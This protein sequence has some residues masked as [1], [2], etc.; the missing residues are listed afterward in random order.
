MDRP[1]P[2]SQVQSIPAWRLT[3]THITP[4]RR[5]T[6]AREAEGGLRNKTFLLPIQ[7]ACQILPRKTQGLGSTK[8]VRSSLPLVTMFLPIHLTLNVTFITMGD[9][10]TRMTQRDSI[11]STLPI[12][13]RCTVGTTVI[14]N[15]GPTTKERWKEYHT[16]HMQLWDFQGSKLL[17]RSI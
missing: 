6:T 7:E 3:P 14:G 5:L 1:T 15:S 11:A 12:A 10:F 17:K 13:H 8:R 16:I 9:T 2:A 4:L